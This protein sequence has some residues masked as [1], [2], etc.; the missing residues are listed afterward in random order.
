M[1][2]LGSTLAIVLATVLSVNTVHAATAQGSMVVTASV[3]GSCAVTPAP[4]AFGVYASNAT[5]PTTAIAPVTVLCTGGVSAGTLTLAAGNSGAG[6]LRQ[7]TGVIATN[8]L[9]YNL[10]QPISG[11][12]LAGCA[13]STPWGSTTG[14][15]GTGLAVTGLT[16]AAVFNVCGS[17]PAGQNVGADA[18][19][20]SVVVTLEF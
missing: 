18:Y 12:P 19:A 1:K 9:S 13:S 10:F 4:L 11:S 20:D 15:H 6:A 14:G 7:M 8:K 16:L 17:I 2:V 5:S 3:L